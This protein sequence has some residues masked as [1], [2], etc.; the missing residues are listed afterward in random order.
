MNREQVKKVNRLLREFDLMDAALGASELGP[1]SD[2]CIQVI[3]S[4]D[5]TGAGNMDSDNDGSPLRQI[6]EDMRVEIITEI[7]RRLALRRD[8]VRESLTELGVEVE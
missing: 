5:V 8:Y 7:K 3:V 6:V 1:L 4:G 2:W